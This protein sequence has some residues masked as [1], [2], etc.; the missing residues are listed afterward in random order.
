MGSGSGWGEYPLRKPQ[1]P[2]NASFGPRKPSAARVAQINPLAAACPTWDRLVQAPSAR[3]CIEPA[4]WESAMPKALT[5]PAA[6]NPGSFPAA[7]AAPKTPQ[8]AVG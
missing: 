2:S 3:N 7:A 1:Y 8:V 6:S 5:I 4:A